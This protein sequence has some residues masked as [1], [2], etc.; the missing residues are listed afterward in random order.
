MLFFVIIPIVIVFPFRM[1]VISN[2]LHGL[3]NPLVF[4]ICRLIPLNIVL[5]SNLLDL[6]PISIG[7]LYKGIPLLMIETLFMV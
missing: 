7:F 6:S 3:C 1:L 2:L 4:L 5:A